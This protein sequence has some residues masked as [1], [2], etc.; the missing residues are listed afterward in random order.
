MV[1]VRE[2][3]AHLLNCILHGIYVHDDMKKENE[4]ETEREK[5]RLPSIFTKNSY[6]LLNTAKRC[7]FFLFFFIEKGTTSIMFIVH[8][9]VSKM[10]DIKGHGY[11]Y[12]QKHTYTRNL[13]T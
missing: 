8:H 3:N 6:T 12:I 2:R 10:S 9:V 11:T 5:D 7:F 13:D 1:C 4:R